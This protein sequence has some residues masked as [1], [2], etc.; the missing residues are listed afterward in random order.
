MKRGA[1]CDRGSFHP[2]VRDEGQN[3]E[4][5]DE[6]SESY[7]EDEDVLGAGP[8]SLGHEDHD[9]EEGVDDED[10]QN[11]EDEESEVEAALLHHALRHHVSLVVRQGVQR[12]QLQLVFWQQPH[13]VTIES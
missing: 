11:E 1:L 6:V 2:K 10:R 3:E 7:T 13:I 4:T 9:D 8:Q 5:L 12:L